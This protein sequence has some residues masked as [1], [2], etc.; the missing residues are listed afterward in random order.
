MTALVGVPAESVERAWPL[1]ETWIAKACK[2]GGELFTADDIKGLLLSRD[3]QLW[4]VI[5]GKHDVCCVCVTEIR[6]YP[7]KRVCSVLLCTGYEAKTWAHHVEEIMGWAKA[8]GCHAFK[9][10]CR[11]GWQRVL[12]DRLKATHVLLEKELI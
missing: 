4:L 7:R 10:L 3:M 11:F 1:A 6:T 2:R 8:Q 9:A 5:D 12:R